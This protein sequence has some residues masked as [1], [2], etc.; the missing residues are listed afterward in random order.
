VSRDVA[1]AVGEGGAAGGI[2]VG[3]SGENAV[4]E[5]CEESG[6]R[7]TTKM[8]TPSASIRSVSSATEEVDKK[9]RPERRWRRLDA[10]QVP[11]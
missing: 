6:H 10:G 8:P 2:T 3:G 7:R 5:R 11:F 1:V 4:A 9:V